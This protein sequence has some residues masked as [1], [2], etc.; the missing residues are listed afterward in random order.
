MESMNTKPELLIARVL[1]GLRCWT[2]NRAAFN[3]RFSR[4]RAAI[5]ALVERCA[6]ERGARRVLIRRPP[7]LEDSSR[8]WS[9]WMTLDALQWKRAGSEGQTH[10]VGHASPCVRAGR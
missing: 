3:A 2:G 10:P 1:F 5:R 7:G 6:A 8:N 4:E 9:V